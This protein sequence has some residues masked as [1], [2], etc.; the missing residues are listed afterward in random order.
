[1][2]LIGMSKLTTISTMLYMHYKDSNCL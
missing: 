1:M 2:L